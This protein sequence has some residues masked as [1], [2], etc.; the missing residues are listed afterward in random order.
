MRL[1]NPAITGSLTVSGSKIVDFTD[2]TRGLTLTNITASKNIISTGA[3]ALIS[4]SSTSTGSFGSVVVSDKVQGNLKIGEGI[5]YNDTDKRLG[6]GDPVPTSPE[7]ELHIKADTPEITIQRTDNDN[8][9][10]I[11]F[12]G[13]AGYVGAKIAHSGTANN[14]VFHTYA[15]STLKERLTITGGSASTKISGSAIS[16]GSFG[17]LNLI[18]YNAGYGPTTNTNFGIDA[19]KSITSGGYNTIV[20]QSAADAITT[21]AQNVC[22]GLSALGTAT[23]ENY[24]V[25]VVV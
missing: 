6:I 12:Q 9:G 8:D 21:G 5:I 15:S 22:I 7:S 16:T 17:Q 4:G 1:H 23:T 2:A 14:L 18:N 25:S 10:V 13:S 11:D 24:N 3:N 19:G 20:G